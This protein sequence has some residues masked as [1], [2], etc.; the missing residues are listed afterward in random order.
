MED[1]IRGEHDGWKWLFSCVFEISLGSDR[2]AVISRVC[3]H[4]CAGDLYAGS[5]C[6]TD[7]CSCTCPYVAG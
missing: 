4:G 1:V 2:N 7:G 3:A 6:Y 5:Y